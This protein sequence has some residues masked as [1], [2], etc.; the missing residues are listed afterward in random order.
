MSAVGN[1]RICQMM[2]DYLKYALAAFDEM[3]TINKALKPTH[4]ESVLNIVS[5]TLSLPLQELER[6]LHLAG[7]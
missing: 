5:K 2:C 7:I 6:A 1:I 4:L 3:A